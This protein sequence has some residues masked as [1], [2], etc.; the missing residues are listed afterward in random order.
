M[1]GDLAD[2]NIEQWFL[3]GEMNKLIGF[4]D[5]SNVLAEDGVTT[6]GSI[7]DKDGNTVAIESAKL[8]SENS[9]F[10]AVAFIGAIG[11]GAS[12]EWVEFVKASMA[13]KN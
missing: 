6:K 1:T 12:N 4:A 7:T 10:E 9:F 11:E 3:A 8:S 2:F 13:R 5:F